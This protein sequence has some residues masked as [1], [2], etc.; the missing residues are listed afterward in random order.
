MACLCATEEDHV[1]EAIDKQ[2]KEEK[3]VFKVPHRLLLLGNRMWKVCAYGHVYRYKRV[4]QNHHCKTN[5]ASTQ[6]WIFQRVS[7]VL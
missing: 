4:R 6:R 7:I 2:L 5:E 1:S 3:K